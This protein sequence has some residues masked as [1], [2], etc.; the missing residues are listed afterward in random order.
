M[1][2]V[3]KLFKKNLTVASFVSEG[4]DS[5]GNNRFAN[6]KNSFSEEFEKAILDI[7]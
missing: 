4:M 2:M 1:D 3:L 6:W 7:K 5:H